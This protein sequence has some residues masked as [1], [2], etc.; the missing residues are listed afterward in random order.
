M[1]HF[2]VC[3]CYFS[4]FDLRPRCDIMGPARKRFIVWPPDLDVL[5]TSQTAVTCRCSTFARV[6]MMLRSG[7]AP[8]LEE[9]G[10][11]PCGRA[12]RSAFAALCGYSGLS[13]LTTSHWLGREA[14]LPSP[15]LAR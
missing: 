2:S 7:M 5:C 1:S 9:G 14:F 12:E 11:Y 4:P 10:G 13:R 3:S 15:L 6:D 8:A